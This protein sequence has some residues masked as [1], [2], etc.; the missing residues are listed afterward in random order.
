MGPAVSQS[1]SGWK[2]LKGS[3]PTPGLIHMTKSITW[4]LSELLLPCSSGTSY[5][6]KGR[7]LKQ[8]FPW[9]QNEPM[10]TV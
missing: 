2:D 9:S 3:S 7:N 4:V 8:F 1:I 6:G 10:T 5:A